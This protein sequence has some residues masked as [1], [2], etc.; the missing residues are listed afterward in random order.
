MS[1]GMSTVL[2][3]V[4]LV[5]MVMLDCGVSDVGKVSRPGFYQGYS[6]KK[7]ECCNRESIYLTMPS[8]NTRIA[9]DIYRPRKFDTKESVD[10]PLPVLLSTTRYHRAHEIDGKPV[11]LDKHNYLSYAAELVQY[12]YVVAIA[13]VR[14]SGA[15]FGVDQGPFSPEE[16]WFFSA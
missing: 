16:F 14:G 1:K 5:G 6:Q 8:D 11:P 3:P 7:Y 4:F 9:I 12:G 2:V 13:D 15:S 10:T